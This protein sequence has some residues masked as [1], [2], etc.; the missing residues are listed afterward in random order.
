VISLTK[1]N[2]VGAD[3]RGRPRTNKANRKGVVRLVVSLT[4]EQM[5]GN[6]TRTISFADATVSDVFS[7]IEQNLANRVAQAA[8]RK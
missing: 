3:G 1:F 6:I 7:A 5:K 4:G 2:R 8:K